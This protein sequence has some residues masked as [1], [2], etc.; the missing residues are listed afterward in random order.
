MSTFAAVALAVVSFLIA[1]AA[2]GA[3]TRV[4]LRPRRSIDEP[5][6]ADDEQAA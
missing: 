2:L 6:G 1:A 5:A 3:L 4:L